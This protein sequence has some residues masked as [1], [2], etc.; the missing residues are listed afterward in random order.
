MTGRKA[1]GQD[2]ELSRL[3]PDILG[4]QTW[5]RL[6]SLEAVVNV[7]R[8]RI[9]TVDPRVRNI[10]SGNFGFHVRGKHHPSVGEQTWSIWR[11]GDYN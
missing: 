10:D 2:L 3:D 9:P 6:R 7:K 5:L 4:A 8:S 11:L 1:V